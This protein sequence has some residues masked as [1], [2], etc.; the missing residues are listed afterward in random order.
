M[1]VLL[2]LDIADIIY[3]LPS[4]GARDGRPFWCVLGINQQCRPLLFVCPLG[5]QTSSSDDKLIKR[6][7]QGRH[8]ERSGHTN[9]TRCNHV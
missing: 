9:K 3:T 1:W 4:H 7:R 5:A 8:H 2:L 6:R